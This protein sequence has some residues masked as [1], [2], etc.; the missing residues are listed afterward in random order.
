M[1]KFKC[2]LAISAK[3]DWM[4]TDIVIFN[5]YW[6]FPMCYTI[7]RAS[8][9][10]LLGQILT[11]IHWDVCC[12]T[13]WPFWWPVAVSP[14]NPII[15]MSSFF[16][17]VVSS[18]VGFFFFFGL[19][20]FVH[21]VDTREVWFCCGMWALSRRY[22]SKNAAIRKVCLH[23]LQWNIAGGLD[24]TGS[25]TGFDDGCLWWWFDCGFICGVSFDCKIYRTKTLDKDSRSNCPGL[26]HPHFA[27]QL[28]FKSIL[29]CGKIDCHCWQCNLVVFH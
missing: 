3:T 25:A 12:A 19:C 13:G 7:Y 15:V 18:F 16:F 11:D 24:E 6:P 9:V 5:Q 21:T 27:N 20:L 26:F 28:A 17:F 14:G 1:M 29:L 23:F 8:P 2:R 4:D 22:A 10:S